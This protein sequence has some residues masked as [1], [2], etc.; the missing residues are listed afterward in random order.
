M[1]VWW[2]SDP[3]RLAR[4]RAS[5]KAL[6]EDWFEHADWSLDGKARLR[7]VFDIVIQRGRFRLAMVYHNTFPA[8]PP[9]VRPLNEGARL[10][11]HQY[12][13]G[14][15]LCLEIR[16]DNWSP[17]IT[18][19]EM[20]RSAHLLLS[21]E[22]PGQDGE[23]VTAP[24]DHDVP[25]ELTLRA[26]GSRFYL[27]NLTYFS[28]LNDK[29]DGAEI[30]IGL[31]FRNGKTII[32]YLLKLVAANGDQAALAVPLG[33]R[34][35]CWAL[36][37]RLFKVDASSTDVSAVKTVKSLADLVGGRFTLKRGDRWTCMVRARDDLVFLVTHLP[38]RDDVLNYDTIVSPLEKRRSGLY[39]NTLSDKRVGIVGLGSLGSKIA[40]S[41]AR[42][43]VGRFELVDGDIL[44]AGNLER[45]DADWRDVGRHK[46]DIAAYRLE[47]LHSRVSAH[48]WQTYIGAQV[49]AEEAGNVNAALDGCNLLIDATANPDVFN[50]LAFIAMRSNRTLVWG[51]VFAGGVGGEIARS[52]PEKDPSPYD[53][54]QVLT[55]VY[56]TT[57]EEA[58]IPGAGDY[59]GSS[60]L[61]EPMVATD[62]DV[63][64]F[65]AHMSSLAIDALLEIEPS[66]FGAPAYLI[67]L[68][69]AWVFD[70]PFDTRPV[71]VD[72]PARA[73]LSQGTK[74]A[75]DSAFLTSLF[76][77]LNNEA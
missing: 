11:D 69:R 15:D 6:G 72:A 45:H 16:S 17:D 7:L 5:I 28:V 47:L 76:E 1:T 30:E 26:S 14:G 32:A 3:D 56:G 46:S 71:E 27:D 52:R 24:S 55:Q 61:E 53:I 36:N 9:S 43:G 65:A 8:S 13:S 40:T 75:L 73:E 51:N 54:R 39:H 59:E 29:N 33:V 49:S 18:G 60:Y 37:G 57:E 19:A 42:A 35:T 41:L 64:V 44:H 66:P 34:E 10:S 22:T 48:P 77:T 2:L 25:Y 68:R 38:E 62:A 23:R 70:A 63:T 4:E 74:V 67:G 31:N 20:V 58:P 21:L 50:H 12:G